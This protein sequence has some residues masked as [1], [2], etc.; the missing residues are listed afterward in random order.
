MLFFAST[1]FYLTLILG[2]SITIWLRHS[3]QERKFLMPAIAFM[4]LFVGLDQLLYSFPSQAHILIPIRLS[5][6]LLLCPSWLLFSIAYARVTTVSNFKKTDLYLFGLSLVPFV[7]SV[8]LPT[9]AFYYQT[10]FLAEPIIFLEQTSFYLYLFITIIY[11]VGIGNL[12]ST[13]RNS[14]H[15]EKWRIKISIFGI[16]VSILSLMLFASQGL[17]YMIIDMRNVPL[18]NAGL[19]VGAL[20]MLYSEWK[21]QSNE[22]LISRKVAFRSVVAAI[23]GIYLVGLGLAREGNRLMGDSFTQT[24]LIISVSL[25]IGSIICVAVSRNLRRIVSIWIQR[26]F[27]DEKYDYRAQWMQFSEYLS[28][29]TGYKSLINSSL[30]SFCETF[31]R[32][33]AIYIPLDTE[34]GN[35]MGQAFYYEI[36]KTSEIDISDE[37]FAQLLH[38]DPKPLFVNDNDLSSFEPQTIMALL[39]MQIGIVLPIRVADAPEGLM[40]LGHPINGKEKYDNEDFDLMEAMGHQIGMSA[41]SF[42]VSEEIALNREIQAFDKLGTFVLHDLKN[43]VYTLSLLTNNARNFIADPVFQTDMVETLS[44]TVGNMKMLISQLPHLPNADT[45]NLDQVY[46]QDLVKQVGN[47]I[48]DAPITYSGANPMVDIDAEQITKVFLNL[49]LNALEAGNNKPVK[50]MVEEENGVPVVHVEDKAGGLSSKVLEKGLFKPF[51]TTKPR[52]MG[53]G[54]FHSRKILEAHGAK[55]TVKNRPGEGC[56]FTVH[57]NAAQGKKF[58]V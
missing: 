9:S 43:Q 10:D 2:L 48:P 11:I 1:L 35:K 20:L 41:K 7:L 6:Q 33:G 24:I 45:L 46:L 55:I 32:I 40:L 34:N 39:R 28:R 14:N 37:A 17:L 52:G 42:R 3:K 27:Y 57:F 56:T 16:G 47:Q 54:L 13:L 25:L 4:A 18:R 58:Q 49:Y 30:M 23:A 5:V 12:E 38:L 36:D 26:N 31:G 29:A 44:N 50:V 8:L 19:C 21:R 51:N 53:I 15:G 22:I